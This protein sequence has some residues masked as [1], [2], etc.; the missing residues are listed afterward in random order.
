MIYPSSDGLMDR[1]SIIVKDRTSIQY[2]LVAGTV[3]STVDRNQCERQTDVGVIL[4]SQ[5]SKR[6]T[7]KDSGY[8]IIVTMDFMKDLTID[9]LRNAA[10]DA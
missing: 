2:V 3:R 4:Q 7:E 5:T 6:N 1:R 8:L 10:E 9:N